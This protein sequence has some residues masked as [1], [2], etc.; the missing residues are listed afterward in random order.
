MT[1]L[2]HQAAQRLDYL[3][4]RLQDLLGVPLQV[5]LLQ[6]YPQAVFILQALAQQA[7]LEQWEAY[8]RVV[9]WTK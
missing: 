2:S 6:M 7:K 3:A 9:L 4:L 5:I 1:K 8:L